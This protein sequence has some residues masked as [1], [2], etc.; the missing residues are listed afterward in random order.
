M[1]DRKLVVGCDM[2]RVENLTDGRTFFKNF[3]KSFELYDEDGV[4]VS[5]NLLRDE[6]KKH[7]SC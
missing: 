4:G 7:S 5:E 1:S 2:T 6:T 3:E